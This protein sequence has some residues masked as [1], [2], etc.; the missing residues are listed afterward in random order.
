MGEFLVPMR[1]DRAPPRVGSPSALS[2]MAASTPRLNELPTE[3]LEHV[4][5]H[6]PGQDIIKVKAARDHLVNSV[7]YSFEYAGCF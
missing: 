4:I 1:L 3:V 2:P 6:L 7:R 5:L